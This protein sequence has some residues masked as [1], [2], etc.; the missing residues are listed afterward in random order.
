MKKALPI[1]VED[2]KDML[3]SDYYYIDKSLFIKELSDLKGK[4][5]LFMRQIGRASCRERV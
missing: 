1:G 5:N 4:V 3:E 2:F